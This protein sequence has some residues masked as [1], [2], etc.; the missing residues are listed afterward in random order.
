[1]L[2]YIFVLL[3]VVLDQDQCGTNHMHVPYGMPVGNIERSKNDEATI[4]NW[5]GSKALLGLLVVNSTY[6]TR[7]VA[8]FYIFVASSEINTSSRHHLHRTLLPVRHSKWFN[9]I[10]HRLVIHPLTQTRKVLPVYH[11][12]Q[13]LRTNNK[14]TKSTKKHPTN[15][16]FFCR[17][18]PYVLRN[19]AMKSKSR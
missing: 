9:V 10:Q 6:G 13:Q 5:A 19:K 1:M 8:S 16:S 18:L 4:P 11:V 3:V 7:V 14:E 15:L 2:Y 12:I 17:T